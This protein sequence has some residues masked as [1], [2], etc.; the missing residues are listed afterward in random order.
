M[1]MNN[2]IIAFNK[3]Q[4]TQEVYSKNTCMLHWIYL[5]TKSNNTNFAG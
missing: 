3:I 1:Y 4:N 2:K 5:K